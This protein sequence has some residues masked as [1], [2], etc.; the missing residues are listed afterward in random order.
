[1]NRYFASSSDQALGSSSTW[2]VKT[3]HTTSSTSALNRT[4]HTA[5]S[6]R[7]TA[8][9][10]AVAGPVR[11]GTGEAPAGGPSCSVS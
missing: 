1:M 10:T 11:G 9:F 3:C 5:V 7:S 8:F 2:R 4:T 6:T